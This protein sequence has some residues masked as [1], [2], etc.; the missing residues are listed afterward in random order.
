MQYDPG[1]DSFIKPSI[2]EANY[3]DTRYKDDNRFR[4]RRR[5]DRRTKRKPL[6]FGPVSYIQMYDRGTASYYRQRPGF[7]RPVDMDGLCGTLCKNKCFV[8]QIE[9]KVVR[10]RRPE[11]ISRQSLSGGLRRMFCARDVWY[12]MHS[13]SAGPRCLCFQ[14]LHIHLV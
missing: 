12:S 6:Q 3:T 7:S 9:S 11:T 1:D 5:D 10:R 8:E 14:D 4:P 13:R 2:I